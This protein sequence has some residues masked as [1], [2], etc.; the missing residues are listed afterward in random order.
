MSY[1]KVIIDISAQAVDRAFTY[2][3]PEE[4]KAE[5]DELRKEVNRLMQQNTELAV[6]NSAFSLQK[7]EVVGCDKRKPPRDF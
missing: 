7:C 5:I 1:A 4:L 2:S 6:K 3:I